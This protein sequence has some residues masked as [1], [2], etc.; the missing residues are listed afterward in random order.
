MKNIQKIKSSISYCLNNE[1][2]NVCKEYLITLLVMMGLY[3]LFKIF[4]KKIMRYYNRY[5][6]EITR[7]ADINNYLRQLKEIIHERK[8]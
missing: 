3:I 1:N 6:W 5:M 8:F 4:K 7:R 2:G